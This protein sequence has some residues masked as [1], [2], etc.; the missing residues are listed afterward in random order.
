[1]Q[2]TIQLTT[3]M[4]ERCS[5][6]D[7]HPVPKCPRCNSEIR[8]STVSGEGRIATFTAIR[9]PPKGFENLAPYVIAI[10]DMRNGPRVIGRVSNALDDV[11]IGS[12]VSL[13]SNKN[14]I[15]EF[16]LST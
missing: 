5:W 9:Y 15:L 3:Y 16:I 13:I 2:S 6:S 1:M 10:I 8:A 7:F 14:G 4:C 11:K 12:A